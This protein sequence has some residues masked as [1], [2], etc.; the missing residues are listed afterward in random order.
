MPEY[1]V[2]VC[3]NCRGYLL[4]KSSYKTRTCPYCGSKIFLEKALK[5]AVAGNVKEA[6]ELLRRLKSGKPKKARFQRLF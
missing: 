5:V 1:M 3:C 2:V 4:A 6:S